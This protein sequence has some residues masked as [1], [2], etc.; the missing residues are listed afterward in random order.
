[1]IRKQCDSLGVKYHFIVG[2]G[3]FIGLVDNKNNVD[4]CGSLRHIHLGWDVK[5]SFESHEPFNP[6]CSRAK[7]GFVT[8]GFLTNKCFE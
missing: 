5:Y 7:M 6:N 3:L 8:Q 1:M 2:L 4:N